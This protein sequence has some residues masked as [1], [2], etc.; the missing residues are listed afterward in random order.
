LRNTGGQPAAGRH[1]NEFESFAKA[2]WHLLLEAI[3]QFPK[4]FIILVIGLEIDPETSPFRYFEKEN[5]EINGNERK[6]TKC[7]QCL[8]STILVGW[9]N[10][11]A[12]LYQRRRR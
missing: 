11:V 1:T 12:C 2:F 6:T 8:T 9:S 7:L 3:P 5:R 4:I 10:E